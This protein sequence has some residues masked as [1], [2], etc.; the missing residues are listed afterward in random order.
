MRPKMAKMT[1]KTGKM[2]PIEK[3]LEKHARKCVCMHAFAFVATIIRPTAKGRRDEKR[4]QTF[5]ARAP[6]AALLA[7]PC[8]IKVKYQTPTTNSYDALA[9]GLANS[10]ENV[11]L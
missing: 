7:D 6:R 1:P 2:T 8:G 10:K 11:R 5:P 3:T 4:G 9:R